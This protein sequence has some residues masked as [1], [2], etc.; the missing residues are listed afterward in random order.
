MVTLINMT[1]YVVQELHNNIQLVVSYAQWYRPQ[2]CYLWRKAL[3]NSSVSHSLQKTRKVEASLPSSRRPLRTQQ[4]QHP[5]SQLLVIL[6]IFR[7]A[8]VGIPA[9]HE[10]SCP[11][12]VVWI[13]TSVRMKATWPKSGVYLIEFDLFIISLSRCTLFVAQ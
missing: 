11:V 3:L 12:R 7:L 5:Y 8:S 10:W 1:Y 2:L 13:R 6:P 4:R 9:W